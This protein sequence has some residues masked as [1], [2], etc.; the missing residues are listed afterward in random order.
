MR[1]SVA[2]TLSALA[3]CTGPNP[4]YRREDLPRHDSTAP[5]SDAGRPSDGAPAQIGTSGCGMARPDLKDLVA[6]DSLAIDRA[7][8]IYFS[9]DDGVTA[10]I[11]KLAPTGA[12]ANKQWLTVTTGLPIRGMAVDSKA[13]VLYYTTGTPTAELQ[14]VDLNATTPMPRTVYRGLIDPNDVAVGFDGRVYVSDQGDSQ[15]HSFTS[16]GDRTTVTGSAIGKRTDYTGPAGL[17]FALDGRLV[18][19]VKGSVPLL[20]LSIGADGKETGR[21]SFGTVS[22][23]ANGVA[24]DER[25]RIYVALYDQ[26]LT[27]DVVRL[28]SDAAAPVPVVKAGHFSSMAFGRGA[29]DC[30]DLYVSDPSPGVVVRRV[31]MDA[32]GQAIP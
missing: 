17:A 15:I 27:K 21:Q 14:A 32:A 19:G 31:T 5:L 7:G 10:R 13:G 2:L 18:V 23:W 26:S 12:A 22:E 11:G 25:G 24:I 16:T 6:V 3:A 28:D 1:A 4:A 9:N 8:N 30:H 29:L 20:R